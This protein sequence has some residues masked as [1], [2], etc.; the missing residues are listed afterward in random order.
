MTARFRLG[1]GLRQFVSL[2]IIWTGLGTAS[3]SALALDNGAPKAARI[4]C[5]TIVAGYRLVFVS[6]SARI[7][8]LPANAHWTEVLQLPSD[9]T[10]EQITKKRNQI[11]LNMGGSQTVG[12]AVSLDT[13]VAVQRVNSAVNDARNGKLTLDQILEKLRGEPTRAEKFQAFEELGKL[14][15]WPDKVWTALAVR[16]REVYWWDDVSRALSQLISRRPWPKSFWS[17][18]L[19]E[20]K[21]GPNVI[22][23][24]I[25]QANW[26]PEIWAAVLYYLNSNSTE[27]IRHNIIDAITGNFGIDERMYG[28][29]SAR[30]QIPPEI[31]AK[32]TELLK[33]GTDA[34]AAKVIYVLASQD[35]S[36]WPP[37]MMRLFPSLLRR[38]IE[39]VNL[40]VLY[41]LEKFA[42]PLSPELV[43]GVSRLVSDPSTLVAD[44]AKRIMQHAQV[45]SNRFAE[46]LADLKSGDFKLMKQALAILETQTEW[47]Q[48]IWQ[49]LSL[50]MRQ[51]LPGRDGVYFQMYLGNAIKKQTGWPLSFW[52]SLEDSML[53]GDA[54]ERIN[55]ITK[56][57]HQQDRVPDFILNALA[58]NILEPLNLEVFEWALRLQYR[59]KHWPKAVI[60][61]LVEL[62]MNPQMEP[63][64]L[65]LI[66]KT[67]DEGTELPEGLP[68][69]IAARTRR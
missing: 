23:A 37:E 47:P 35:M 24:L 50:L 60:D 27:K 63:K 45:P 36:T 7:R 44:R 2:S 9:A 40:A 29:R 67:L 54:Q 30:L 39:N 31:W 13:Q 16:L 17:A 58:Q 1:I 55:A 19:E 66:D 38:S 61:R 21:R 5:D 34:E 4:G 26:P 42:V 46:V 56:L 11:L 64:L 12:T 10:K 22:Y 59:Q 6:E 14:Q 25:W 52:R 28:T 49:Q 68:E 33:T 69:A 51:P 20:T 43:S 48:E 15:D 62:I 57:G 65:E 32:L 53:R 41:V 18:V 8:N 3:Y